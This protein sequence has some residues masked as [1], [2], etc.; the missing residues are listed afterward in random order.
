MNARERI[1]GFVHGR[2]SRTSPP[3]TNIYNPAWG[4]SGTRYNTIHMPRQI[5]D[6]FKQK[7]EN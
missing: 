7:T 1:M 2:E 4:F 5:D 3:R 6:G